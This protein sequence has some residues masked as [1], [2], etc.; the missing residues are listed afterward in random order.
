[1][2]EEVASSQQPAWVLLSSLLN[3]DYFPR[4]TLLRSAVTMRRSFLRREAS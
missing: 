1:M 4:L 2:A 3:A